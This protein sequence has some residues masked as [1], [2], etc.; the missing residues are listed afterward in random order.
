MTHQHS[1]STVSGTFDHFHVGHAQIIDKAFSLA[2]QVSVGISDGSML[3]KKSFHPQIELY[4]MRKKYLE[5]Y[6]KAKYPTHTVRFFRLTDIYGIALTDKTLDS[7]VVTR[8]TYANAATINTKRKQK[9]WQPLKIYK[10]TFVKDPSGKIIRSTRIR[11]GEI[12][13]K[14]SIY[15]HN[16]SNMKISHLPTKMRALLREP[17]GQVVKG[18][19]DEKEKTA[20]KALRILQQENPPFI[21][22]VGDIVSSSMRDSGLKIDLSIID[23]HTQR[24]RV[25]YED[26]GFIAS[27]RHRYLNR[28][29]SISSHVAKNTYRIIKKGLKKK[30]NEILL[31]RGEEDLIALPAILLAPL[32]SYV[33][34]GQVGLG[35]VLTKVTEEKKKR[36]SELL[37]KFE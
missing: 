9:G 36:V 27:N 13:R 11:Q 7:I 32:G 6:V 12:D 1:H 31:I 17:F 23:F 37:T 18:K 25:V 33:V 20:A 2:R 19:E 28:A 26:G 4:D 34:Y 15:V 14:G 5:D 35:I 29:G 3:R 30:Q 8:E 24:G 16:F 22:T 21:I 10:V